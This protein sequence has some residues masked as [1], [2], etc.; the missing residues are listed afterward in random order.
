MNISL[1]F[2][3]V[4]LS[5][6]SRPQNSNSSTELLRHSITSIVELEW[7]GRAYHRLWTSVHR[8]VCRRFVNILTAGL[9]VWALFK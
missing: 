3:G 4:T 7:K 1:P 8:G 6:S 2:A 5:E 9:F